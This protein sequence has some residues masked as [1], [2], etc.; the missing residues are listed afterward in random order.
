MQ[1]DVEKVMLE[2]KR[3]IVAQFNPKVLDL[4]LDKDTTDIVDY[5]VKI[6]MAQA[7]VDNCIWFLIP[8]QEILSLDP[9]IGITWE[10]EEVDDMGGITLSIGVKVLTLD[11]ADRL[12]DVRALRYR[13]VL[14]H[15]FQKN[16]YFGGL[17][18]SRLKNIQPK[19]I[20]FDTQGQQTWREVGILLKTY[21]PGV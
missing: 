8:K 9:T 3:H 6:P 1:Y 13:Q 16:R 5:G 14:Y 21:F 11:K 19:I 15:I 2:I 10:D 17:R 4:N 20:V 12:T 18:F 7:E